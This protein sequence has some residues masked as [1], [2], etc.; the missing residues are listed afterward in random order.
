MET[1]ISDDDFV[2]ILSGLTAEDTVAYIPPKAASLNPL[3]L[4][5]GESAAESD[6]GG[7]RG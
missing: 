4:M 6:G 5:M 3:L 7:G 1:G 2:Q